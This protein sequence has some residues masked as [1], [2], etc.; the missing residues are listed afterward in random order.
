VTKPA[1]TLDYEGRAEKPSPLLANVAFAFGCIAIAY[2]VY[3]WVNIEHFSMSVPYNGA[4]LSAI[5]AIFGVVGRIL[6]RRRLAFA[7]LI[8]SILACGSSML[9]YLV[10]LALIGGMRHG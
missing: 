7:G 4:A 8:L 6:T 10:I 3:G 2:S 1:P 5:G 9:E